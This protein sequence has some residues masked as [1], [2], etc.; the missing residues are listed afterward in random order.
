MTHFPPSACQASL[1]WEMEAEEIEAILEKIWDLHDK[2]SDA[3]HSV[4]KAHFLSS[5]KPQEKPSKDQGGFVFMK[6]C[7]SDKDELSE[8]RSLNAIRTALENLEDHLEFYHT[9]QSQQRAERD[10]AIA[11]LEQSRLILAMKLADYHG[12]KY[13]VIEEA[14]A[15]VGSVDENFVAPEDLT[16]SQMSKNIEVLGSKGSN[17]LMQIFASSFNLVRRSLKLETVAG[18]IGNAALIAASMIAVLQLQQLTVKG[19]YLLDASRIE[20]D[21]HLGSTVTQRKVL[22]REYRVTK[23]DV[24]LAR[25]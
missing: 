14:L 19:G 18:L 13:S 12:K 21:A 9:V 11:Q 25:G 6:E 4:S 10:A 17:F 22:P 3:I 1:R 5:T 7:R 23:L 24:L 2:I 20:E 16:R 8:A 15:F